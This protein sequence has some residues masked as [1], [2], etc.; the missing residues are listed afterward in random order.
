MHNPLIKNEYNIIVIIETNILLNDSVKS[1]SLKIETRFPDIF[2]DTKA[3]TKLN[4]PV[5]IDEIETLKNLPTIISLDLIGK[6]SNV[7][8]VPL[9][10]SPAVESVAG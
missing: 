9:S 8:S 6:V 4:T 10:F 7:S 5:T 3:N 2:K 1:I